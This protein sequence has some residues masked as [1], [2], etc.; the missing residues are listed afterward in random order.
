MLMTVEVRS[1][2]RQ[3]LAIP[4][5]AILD[6]A[7]G[8]RAWR[9]VTREGALMTEVVSIQTGQRSG[10]MAEVL[11][12]LQVGD[13][14]IVEGLQSVRPGQPVQLAPA[15]DGEGAAQ[16]PDRRRG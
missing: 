11:S 13:Q 9:V 3:A 10:G 14:I 16:A 6:E 1:N 2:P 4:E 8:S 15:Q 12:G 5:I 7:S